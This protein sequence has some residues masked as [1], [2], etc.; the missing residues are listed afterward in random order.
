LTI[1]KF[2][3]RKLTVEDL[4]KLD[5]LTQEAADFLGACVRAKKNIVV[6]GG[7]GSGKT[8]LLNIL[9]AFIPAAERIVT[10][11]DSAELQLS[12]P[13]VVRLEGRPANLEGKGQVT[14][15]DLVINALRMRPD[16][17]IVGEVR[18]GEA[19][20]ML[21]A[22]NTGHDGSLTTGHAN[23]PRD[24]LARLETMCLF[25][26]LNL[27]IQA[28]REQIARAIQLVVQQSRLPNGKRAVVKI[29]EIQGMEADVILLQDLFA[30]EEEKGLTRKSFAP[31]FIQDLE[32]VGYRWP[33]HQA[34]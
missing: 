30:L 28:I 21:Q 14:I 6:S 20:D 13:H 33:G 17:I 27:P 29:S 22:M 25:T 24:M 26:G 4:I 18:A 1:R 8:T 7:T 19:L 31:K 9:S 12:Q 23:S 15:R 3:K 5:S 32:A 10:I 16:R 34:R 11:E 2:S